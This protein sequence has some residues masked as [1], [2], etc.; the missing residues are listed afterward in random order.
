[1]N[2]RR[3]DKQIKKVA[4]DTFLLFRNLT[5]V[6]MATYDLTGEEIIFAT[7]E[8]IHEVEFYFSPK[9]DSGEKPLLVIA[10][11]YSEDEVI[12]KLA[13]MLAGKLIEPE[14]RTFDI[15]VPDWTWK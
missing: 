5:L 14:D 9:I 6:L 2:I 10:K 4:L 12:D 3:I 8:N 7:L 13:D 15:K 11:G 1:M